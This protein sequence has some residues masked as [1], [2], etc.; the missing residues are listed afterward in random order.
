MLP[1]KAMRRS[2]SQIT[3]FYNYGADQ[4]KKELDKYKDYVID[5]TGVISYTASPYCVSLQEPE[6][7]PSVAQ[8]AAPAASPPMSSDFAV[9]PTPVPTKCGGI[10][11]Q[12]LKNPKWR[13]SEDRFEEKA[14][15]FADTY[16]ESLMTR[17][18]FQNPRNPFGAWNYESHVVGA[19][20]SGRDKHRMVWTCQ[21]ITDGTNEPFL[22]GNQIDFGRYTFKHVDCSKEES[23]LNNGLCKECLDA[24]ALLLRR[25]DNNVNLHSAEFNPKRNKQYESTPSLMDARAVWYARKLKQV[26]RRLSYKTRALEKLI[27]DTGVEC[28]INEDSD[29]IFDMTMEENVKQFLSSDPNDRL[30]AIAQYVF[31]EACMKHEQAKQHGRK[32]IRHSPLVI[33]LAAAVYSKMGDAGGGYDLLARCFNLPT[34]RTIR[35]YTDN[36]AS[37]ADGILHRNLRAAQVCFDERNPD[38]PVDDDKRAVI[39]KLDEMHVRGRFGVDFHTNKVVGITEDALDK[40]VIERE[41]K[42][43]LSVEKEDE[44]DVMQEVTVPQPNKKF[45]VFVAT[46]ADKNQ[47]KQQIVV[48]RYGV[49]SA[50]SEFIARRLLELPVALY[51]YG[52]IVRHIGCDGATEIRSALHLIGNVS[53]QEVLGDVFKEDELSGLPMDFIVGYKHPSEGCEN[54]TILF[55]GDMPHWVKKFRNA[56]DNKSREL[57]YRGRIM[58]LAALK[59]I[60]E[61]TESPGSNLCKTRFTYDYFELDSYKK[62]RVFLATGFASDSMIDMIHDYCGVG[63]EDGAGKDNVKNYEGLIQL[64]SAVNRLV[65]I[66]NAYDANQKTESQRPRNVYPIDRP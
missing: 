32:S 19:L 21:E 42:E 54:V 1:P 28:P 51:E 23:N 43:L 52:F 62:M 24:K 29:R 5:R 2:F 63:K 65:D 49:R 60:W 66:C 46:I 36:S 35:N 37:E 33:R 48:A 31:T 39:L 44:D 47:V 9:S 57:T 61:A 55:G 12:Y 13:Y 34:G 14:L 25:F 64:L 7:P 4:K 16:R 56:F 8:P 50:S 38:C 6:R 53:A 11:I 20:S 30:A 27:E 40:S 22:M 41:L 10:S 59:L 17:V 18:H 45:L 3:A 15:G 26:T 58:R